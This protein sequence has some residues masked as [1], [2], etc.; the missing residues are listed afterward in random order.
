MSAAFNDYGPFL[1]TEDEV[2]IVGL[3]EHDQWRSCDRH[4]ICGETVKNRDLLRVKHVRDSGDTNYHGKLAVYSI[5]DGEMKCCVGYLKKEMLAFVHLYDGKLLLMKDFSASDN[6]Q[7]CCQEYHQMRGCG[8]AE[9]VTLLTD[10]AIKEY[11]LSKST[12]E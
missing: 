2:L 1:P 8:M 9:V 10:A 12:S 3:I 7:S 11:T 5:V 4:Y 6:I